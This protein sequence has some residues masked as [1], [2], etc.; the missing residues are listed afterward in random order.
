MQVIF[1]T[2]A[3]EVDAGF[4]AI[5]YETYEEI[6]EDQQTFIVGR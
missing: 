1:H 6:P 2:D 4:L 3:S 5:A